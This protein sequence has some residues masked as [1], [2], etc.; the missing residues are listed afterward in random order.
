MNRTFTVRVSDSAGNE[1]VGSVDFQSG[2]VETILTGDIGGLVP[3]GT[4]ARLRGNCRLIENLHVRG[5]LLCDATGVDLDGQNL[6]DIHTHD[7]TLN[8][9][10]QEK[11]A[12]SGWGGQR[13]V[14]DP[15]VPVVGWQ[16]GD[17]LA[18]APTAVGV[19]QASETV[20]T[21]DW[22][23][24]VRPVNSPNVT[25]VDGRV[26]LP[27]VV[28]LSQTVTLRNLKRIMIHE[29]TAPNPQTM[30]WI[31]V[32][33]SGEAGVLGNYPIHFHLIGNHARG[34]LLEG[35]VVEGGKN[36]AFVPHGSHGISFPGCVAYKTTNDA[37]WWDVIPATINDS[38]DIDWSDC[39]ALQVTAV[40]GMLRTTG[41]VIGA[42]V[43]NKCNR[44]VA[45]GTPGKLNFDGSRSGFL[46]PEEA[47]RQPWEFKDCL[48]HNNVE[49]GSFAWQNNTNHHLI[50]DF[51]TYRNGRSGINHG[52]Y[53]N[54]YA[55]LGGSMT[56]DGF[57][58]H[59]LSR[60]N[61]VLRVED[62]KTDAPL[63]VLTHNFAFFGPTVFRNIDKFSQVVYAERGTTEQGRP[64][65]VQFFDCGLHPTDFRLFGN[66]PPTLAEIHPSSIIEIFEGGTLVHRWQSGVWS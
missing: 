5:T 62:F 19:F 12:W 46:W 13:F 47:S 23:T 6:F 41:F 29:A 61:V 63:K 35:V 66:P 51:T 58:L 7:G 50:E 24:M 57:L 54:D 39:L 22:A 34:S 26:A 45:V 36:H 21:G 27:E 49:N 33:N 9:V 40:P 10:G 16:P 4:T 1:T 52:A 17:R 42:G 55:Y 53:V 20:W 32:L 3:A 59:A 8:L 30:K 64:S 60:E 11:T 28:N 48:A 43:G 56:G 25:L 18:V 37:F 31:R 38:N 65:W 14:G 2:S 15:V 44:S